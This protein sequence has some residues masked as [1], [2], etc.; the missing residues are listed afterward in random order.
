MPCKNCEKLRKDIEELEEALVVVTEE[1][2]EKRQAI[3]QT[4]K[5]LIKELKII[6]IEDF[7]KK[8]PALYH[9][10]MYS[11][12]DVK[13]SFKKLKGQGDNKKSL[14]EKKGE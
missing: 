8:N 3:N 6:G 14:K 11:K 9:L 13:Q 10:E 2:K 1:L 7:P 5:E 4:E 12:G